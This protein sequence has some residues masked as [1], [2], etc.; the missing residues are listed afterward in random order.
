MLFNLT[1]KERI[2]LVKAHF[3]INEK[4]LAELSG[5]PRGSLYFLITQADSNHPQVKKL[6]QFLEDASIHWQDT[7]YLKK[8]LKQ[9]VK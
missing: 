7:D 3:E 9:G 5:V 4:Q 8:K 2:I 6:N 1:L